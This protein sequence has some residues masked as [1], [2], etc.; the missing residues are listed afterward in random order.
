MEIVV[1]KLFPD[2]FISA[3]SL[4][5]FSYLAFIWLSYQLG[6]RHERVE[7]LKKR[8]RKQMDADMHLQIDALERK[9][10]RLRSDNTHE[11][12]AL[13]MKIRRLR[14]RMNSNK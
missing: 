11:R 8:M 7:A 6:E 3:T 1:A 9:M 14:R 5:V 13:E 12:L 4:A 10:R 2:L